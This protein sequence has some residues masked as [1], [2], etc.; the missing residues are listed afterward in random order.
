MSVFP[1]CKY[2]IFHHFLW[3]NIL[4]PEI[5]QNLMQIQSDSMLETI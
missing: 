4:L 2:Y 5:S 3:G 1:S